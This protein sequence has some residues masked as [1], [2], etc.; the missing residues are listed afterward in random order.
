MRR[1]FILALAAALALTVQ[2]AGALS[3][4]AQECCPRP[5]ASGHS[6]AAAPANAAAPMPSMDTDAFRKEFNASAD[7]VRVVALLSPTCPNCQSG[8]RVVGQVLKKFSSPDL[9]ALVVWEPMREGDTSEAAAQLAVTLPD[10][11]ITQGWNENRSVGKLFGETLDLHQIAWD[12]YL[13][14]K[15]GIKW[16]ADRHQPPPPTFWMH[17]LEGVDPSLLLCENPARLSAEVAKLLPQSE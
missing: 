17:Q 11:R 12:V 3:A 14:Y 15:P 10:T 7:K 4:Y 16:D 13:L 6:P 8:H 5:A 9:R 1:L 2:W